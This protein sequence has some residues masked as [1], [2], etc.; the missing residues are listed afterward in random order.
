MAAVSD[1]DFIL[2]TVLG[3]PTDSPLRKALKLAGVFNF[4]DVMN[5][6]A[7]NIDC[8]KFEDTSS[9]PV[10]K[11]LPLGLQSLIRVLQAFVQQKIL[12][13]TPVHY[14]LQNDLKLAEFSEYRVM[15]YKTTAIKPVQDDDEDVVQTEHLVSF[16]ST[17][18]T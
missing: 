5:L 3:Q 6:S 9:P 8:L 1:V 12:D 11:Q 15:V 4:R 13:G 7:Q 14:D 18:S 2:T 17:T 16:G 10:T